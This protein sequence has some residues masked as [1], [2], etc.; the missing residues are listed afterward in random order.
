M[1]IASVQCRMLAAT[2][3]RPIQ[4]GIGAF[5]TFSATLV[6]ITTDDGLSGVGECIVRK[7][8]R[9]TRTVVE[10]LLAPVLIGRDPHDAEG[11]WDEMFRQLRGW[12]HYR[13]FVFEA[14]SG[15]D[16]ALW[17]ILGQAAGLPVYKVLGGAG[18]TQVPCYASS[19]YFADLPTMVEEAR[20]QVAAGHRAIKVKIGRPP[21]LGGRR[22]DV[23]SVKAIRDALGPEVD[24]MLDANS[25]YDAATA[26]TVCRQLE[27]EDITWIEEPVPADDLDGYR[28]VREGQS[29]P[30]AAG[31][32]E[33]GVFGFRELILR[34]AI[35]I[36]QPDV[37]RVGGF[38]AARR[39][40]A[41]V[42][43]HNLRYA[44]H[45]GF[46]AG[47]SHLA[48]LHVAAAVPNLMTY[49]YFYAPNPL[50]DLFTE[51]FPT[52]VRGVVDVPQRPGLGLELD[53]R[54]VKEFELT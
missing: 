34:G 26:I 7:A 23:A 18:R 10:E 19:V 2:L 15:I 43:A 35:D 36:V 38:T 31:E 41:L 51:P 40:G 39:V 47:V 25:A 9:V 24:I 20:A 4:F 13:G 22:Q 21:D 30:V 46:S 48:A 52:P 1:K 54:V 3:P 28:K 32:S 11:L 37:A 33:F 14:I 42:H 29:I 50:R 49:E 27:K 5:P 17:D 53:A 8:P 45:T 44:P 6:R 12:G 16:T